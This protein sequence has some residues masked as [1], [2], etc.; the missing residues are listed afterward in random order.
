MHAAEHSIADARSAC[1][2]AVTSRSLRQLRTDWR[3]LLGLPKRILRELL[4]RY[5]SGHAWRGPKHGFDYFVQQV[6]AA[7]SLARV[8]MCPVNGRR[9]AQAALQP[10]GI[11]S[12]ARQLM[13]G[14]RRLAFR[15]W[16]IVVL[17]AWLEQHNEWK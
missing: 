1:I 6:L 7:D 16:T 17:G 13:K 11:G 3:C 15:V 10:D 14:D 4:A 12:Y 9:L 8:R 5:A 2:D